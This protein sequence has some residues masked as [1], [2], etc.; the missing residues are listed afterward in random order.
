ML[1]YCDNIGDM[2]LCDSL[3]KMGFVNKCP[4]G[5]V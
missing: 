1:V 2:Y 3:K 4:K 5:L